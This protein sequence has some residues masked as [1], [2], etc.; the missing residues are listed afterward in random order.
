MS[1]NFLTSHFSFYSISYA[2]HPDFLKVFATYKNTEE[3][4]LWRVLQMP[5]H[6]S[7]K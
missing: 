3:S 7:I 5:V 1:L 2:A 4:G 6:L